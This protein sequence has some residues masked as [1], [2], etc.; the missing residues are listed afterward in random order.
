[1]KTR[2]FNHKKM[3]IIITVIIIA[4][5]IVSYFLNRTFISVHI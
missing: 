2:L 5:V 4:V 1:M 3:I